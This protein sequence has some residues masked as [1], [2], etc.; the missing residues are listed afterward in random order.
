MT[1]PLP[2][3]IEHRGRFADLYTFHWNETS[4]R[5]SMI[6]VVPVAMALVIGVHVGHPAAGLI[7]GGGAM[8]IGFGMNQRIADSR[9]WPMIAATLV[10]TFSTFVGMFA[11]H[12]GY[13]VV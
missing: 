8:Q 9:L 10:M 5:T 6:A 2:D 12:H 1:T 3:P 7:M 4:F 13:G 11:G